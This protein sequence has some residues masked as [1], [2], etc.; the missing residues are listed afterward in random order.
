MDEMVLKAQQFVNT[1]YAAQPDIPTVSEDG[2]TGW[3][4]MYAL[5]RCL[6]YEIGITALSDSFGP[7][8]LSA[9]TTRYPTIDG[10]TTASGPV[11]VV[12]IMQ[13]AMYC[14]GYDGGEWQDHALPSGGYSSRVAAGV[15]SMKQNA[16]VAG[17]WP[18]DAM[19][20]KLFKALLTMDA[21][22]VI[23]GGNDTV[24]S[25]QQWM[26]GSYVGRRNFF[27]IPCDGF[28]SRDVQK[29]LMFAVQ[30]QIGMSDDVANGVF[31]PGTQSGLKANP[32]SVGSSGRWVQLFTAAM[33]FNRRSGVSF[34]G[35][36][37]SALSSQVSAFQ[38][39]V[40]LPVTG[41]GDFQTWASLLVSTGDTSRR[42]RAVDC[43]TQ[44]TYARADTLK[45]NGYDIVGR[46]L[47]NVPGTS[48]NKMIQLG[49]LG[50][51][52]GSGLRCFPIYQTYGDSASYFT[53]TQG[54]I[55]AHRAI[56]RA[57]FYGFKPGTRI[58]FAVDFDALDSEVTSRVLPHFRGIK[59]VMDE[60]GSQYRVGVYGPRNI[61]S[62]VAAAGLSSASF[63]SDMST[64]YSGNLGY[65]MPD[66]WAFDQISTISI[67]S[68]DGKIEIDNNIVSGRDLG[69]SSFLEG[70]W[71]ANQDV[72][73]NSAQLA[74]L[75]ADIRRYLES[76]GIAENSTLR[77]F[78]TTEAVKIAMGWD[79]VITEVARTLQ[80]RK[81]LIVTPILWET[82]MTG[83]DDP[84]ID[85]G[86]IQYHT[87]SD[88]DPTNKF[89][90]A[91][92]STGLGQIFAWVAIQARNYMINSGFIGGA[93]KDYE[94]DSDLWEVWQKLHNDQKYNI[95]A[96][97]QNLI[98]SAMDLGL[99]RPHL[100]Y[101]EEES[102]LVMRRYQGFLSEDTELNE[103]LERE[104]RIKL[105][106]YQILEN[107]FAPLRA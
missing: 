69:Q 74:A 50:A 94:K 79:S 10:A 18:G 60:Y 67:G 42:G 11:A 85:A 81:A 76:Q 62:R 4:T 19:T 9:L 64:G 58:Y 103:K 14:K 44:I 89:I 48:L 53:S 54:S 21:Y 56:E 102:R 49:E 2:N 88:W 99:P 22:T 66:D 78:S 97:S 46:Y 1:Y 31:G 29:A 57:K 70:E 95:N 32:L 91:D 30:F 39:F 104:S 84:V 34:S 51:I 96:A 98:W 80:M 8:T 16:G 33:V 59:E 3:A 47:S 87:G 36:F 20:P 13:A 73:F 75:T 38:D 28:F 15:R 6:Q 92:C 25:I 63:V 90:V 65:P 83:V 77:V 105:G 17:A 106:I 12:R 23:S 93:L 72:N 37:S 7:A 52:E 40:A 82:R 45:A 43:V 71:K 100:E 27:V 35:S 68:G 86:V 107:Y 26:N 41:R 61:C 24:R 101:T 55:D 5:T